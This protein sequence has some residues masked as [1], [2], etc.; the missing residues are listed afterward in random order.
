MP[1]PSACSPA[2]PALRRRRH[3]RHGDTAMLDR[4][5][6]LRMFGEN[7]R[8]MEDA[9]WD[10]LRPLDAKRAYDS[11]SVGWMY[12]TTEMSAALARSQLRKLEA[13]NQQA[14]RNAARCLRPSTLPGITPPTSFLTAAARFTSIA[15]A[16]TQ[17]PWESALRP[18]RCARCSSKPCAPRAG[19]RDVAVAAGARSDAVPRQDRLWPWRAVVGVGS[20]GLGAV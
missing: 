15:C 1:R 8:Q 2:E 20:R 11:I 16:S 4:A 18:N 6:S 12:R 17:R 9:P 5:N 7:V 14:C 3:L 19:S 13:A 10:P